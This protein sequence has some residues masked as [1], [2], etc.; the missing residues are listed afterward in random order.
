MSWG[1]FT[2]L[3]KTCLP[4]SLELLP[5]VACACILQGSFNSVGRKLLPCITVAAPLT[6]PHWLRSPLVTMNNKIS[7]RF[8]LRLGPSFVVGSARGP[9]AIFDPAIGVFRKTANLAST[10]CPLIR[11]Q[12]H[13]PWTSSFY[14]VGLTFWSVIPLDD[15]SMFFNRFIWEESLGSTSGKFSLKKFIRQFTTIGF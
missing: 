1:L 9:P 8:C 2:L 12:R 5:L 11:V 14:H 10:L 3:R 13:R 4:A 7:D 15:P 6:E